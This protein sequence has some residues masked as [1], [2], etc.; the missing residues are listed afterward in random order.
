MLPMLPQPG[1]FAKD[2]LL[3]LLLLLLLLQS[4]NSAQVLSCKLPWTTVACGTCQGLSPHH[5]LPMV[6]PYC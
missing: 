5:C 1:Y 6:A 4:F 2:S 3:L